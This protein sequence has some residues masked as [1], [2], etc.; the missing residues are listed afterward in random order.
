MLDLMNES[1]GLQARGLYSCVASSSDK[2]A[3]EKK[4]YG[5]VSKEEL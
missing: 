4:S 5:T 2:G 1:Y 3:P